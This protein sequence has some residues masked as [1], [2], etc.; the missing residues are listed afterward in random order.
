MFN[1]ILVGIMAVAAIVMA[2]IAIRD[3]CRPA[4]QIEKQ[5]Q[6]LRDTVYAYTDTGFTRTVTRINTVYRQ[7]LVEVQKWVFD[8]SWRNVCDSFANGETMEGCQ[9]MVVRRLIAGERDS[10]LL[11]LYQRQRTE[12]SLQIGYLMKLDS[13]N[14]EALRAAKKPSKV[15]DY[16][17]RGDRLKQ[18][19]KIALSAIVGFVVGRL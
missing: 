16:Q 18:V 10:G 13:L 1:R 5:I 4:T 15:S 6:K 7:R 14:S 11:F 12:D 3:G 2:T 8:S 17:N 9:R 19:G